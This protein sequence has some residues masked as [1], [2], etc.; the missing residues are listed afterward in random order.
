MLCPACENE[1]ANT[2]Q[3]TNCGWEFVYFTQEPTQREQ[4]EYTSSLQNYRTELYFKL[5]KQY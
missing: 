2:Q 5:A 3:C 1:S 4:D